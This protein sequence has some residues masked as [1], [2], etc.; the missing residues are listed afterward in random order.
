MTD[1]I[2][3][4]LRKQDLLLG[5]YLLG[6]TFFVPPSTEQPQT[7]VT[8]PIP[9][10]ILR[11]LPLHNLSKSIFPNGLPSPFDCILAKAVHHDHHCVPLP[12]AL[13]SPKYQSKLNSLSTPERWHFLDMC[14]QNFEDHRTLI[15]S[16]NG[17]LNSLQK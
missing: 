15:E 16:N 3:I 11:L 14:L 17:D 8:P 6:Y 9:A 1:R 7:E 12:S 5:R 2:G 13:S 4:S 10:H